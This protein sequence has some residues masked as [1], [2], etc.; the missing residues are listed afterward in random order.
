MPYQSCPLPSGQ[1]LAWGLKVSPEFRKF[2]WQMAADFQALESQEDGANAFM[3]CMA[4]ET[5]ETFK[6]DIRPMRNGKPLSSA[7]GL[8]Q[9]LEAVAEELGTTTAALAAMS[10]EKQLEYVWLYFRMV[11]H[12][13]KETRFATL[14]DIYMAI[15]WPAAVGK[16]LSHVMYVE[17][18]SAYAANSSLDLNK[19]HQITK[20]EAGTLVRQKLVKG[21]QPKYLG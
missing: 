20:A 17:G 16:P 7:V 10:A 19:D 3:S 15:H 12:R 1:K 4:F 5:M 9:F 8:I 21:L 6:P 14:E 13:R 18:S 11:L 2:V